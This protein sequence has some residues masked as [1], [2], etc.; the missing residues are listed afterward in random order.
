MLKLCS[1]Y[2]MDLCEALPENELRRQKWNEWCQIYQYL[3]QC[4][5]Y[6]ASAKLIMW[7]ALSVILFPTEFPL[8]LFMSGRF[9]LESKL[10][11]SYRFHCFLLQ[12]NS[13]SSLCQLYF[14]RVVQ[15]FSS[16]LDDCLHCW[17]QSN[18]KSFN[19]LKWFRSLIN[20]KEKQDL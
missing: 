3:V 1:H 5:Q 17:L 18:L 4:F 8:H 10:P 6:L 12:F 2:P 7:E 14:Q 20:K 9:E 15:H 16:N 11:I 13:H 19:I